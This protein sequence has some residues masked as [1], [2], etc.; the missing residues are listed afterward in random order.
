MKYPAIRVLKRAF[1]LTDALRLC[2]LR[3]QA[4]HDDDALH[5]YRVATRRLCS[6]L[7]PFDNLSGFAAISEPVRQLK[8]CLK[9]SNDLRDLEVQLAL[10]S[11]VGAD[12]TEGPQ[13][14][15]MEAEAIRDTLLREELLEHVT[16]PKISTALRHVEMRLPD[17]LANHGG[18]SLRRAVQA[19]R[20]GLCVSIDR[21]LCLGPAL[22]DEHLEWH[23]LR[24]DCKRLRYIGESHGDLLGEGWE[25]E[26]SIARRVQDGLGELRDLDILMANLGS[27]ADMEEGVRQ[28]LEGVRAE[29][30][31][32]AES[33]VAKLTQYFSVRA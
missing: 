1:S 11:A 6:I 21:R 33:A 27:L 4:G 2:R 16:S 28:K 13:R 22:F 5:D 20:A 29:R 32:A 23:S 25:K 3:L 30:Q 17:A 9:R 12:K 8:R 26:A 24:I 14:A 31:T 18:H 19:Y 15:W 10:L 7:A